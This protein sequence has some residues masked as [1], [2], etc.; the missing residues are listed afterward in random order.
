MN[1]AQVV[2]VLVKVATVAFA[3]FAGKGYITPDQAE[4]G[5]AALQSAA[6]AVVA[7]VAAGLTL[8]GIFRSVRTHADK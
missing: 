8:Y 6:D 3:F 7:V 1:K 4:A 5:T 2:S